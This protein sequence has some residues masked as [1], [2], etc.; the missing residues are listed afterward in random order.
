MKKI[1]HK[2]KGTNI[3]KN[4][5]LITTEKFGDLDCNFYR[6]MNDDI[7]LTR[8]Q[9]GTALEYSDPQKALNNIHSRHKE[10]LN[11]LSVVYKV[12]GTDGKEYN[13]TLYTQRGVMEICRW[14][15]KPKANMF[16]DWVWDIVEKYRSEGTQ[17]HTNMRQ[18]TD[19]LSTLAQIVTTMANNT[20]DQLSKIDDR[21]TQLEQS[22]RNRYLLEKRY[23]SAWYKKMAPKYKLLQEY[24]E[25]TRAE[26]Y[27]NIY[28]ELEDTYDL[29]INQIHEDYCYEN[30]LLKDE[31]YPM[32]AIEH[33]TKLRDALTLLIDTSLIKYG[34]R[35][36]EQIKNFKRETL[37]DR[38]PI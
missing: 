7:L 30:H 13:T 25:C 18:L 35:T 14:S 26:L 10:R 31:C 19:S 32:D 27:S 12:R 11:E 6:N 34:L 16:M 24:F 15:Q 9:I 38:E 2:K 36:E 4:L 23:P 29:D 22:Q 28:K 17:D 33:N 21:L 5:K 8:E 20:N 3:M 37:F 1:L